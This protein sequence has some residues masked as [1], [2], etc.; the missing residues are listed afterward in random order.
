MAQLHRRNNGAV[1]TGWIQGQHFEGPG[2][3]NRFFS[4]HRKEEMWDAG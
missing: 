4:N 1:R 3:P 2:F